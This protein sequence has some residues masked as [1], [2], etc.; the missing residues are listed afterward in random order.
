[1][2]E[3]SFPLHNTMTIPDQFA[4]QLHLPWSK[5]HFSYEYLTFKIYMHPKLGLVLL[6]HFLGSRKPL[7]SQLEQEIECMK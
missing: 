3:E 1:M 6:Y 7:Y 5:F 2:L 4:L